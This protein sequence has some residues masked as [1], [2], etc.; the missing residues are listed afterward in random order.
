[1]AATAERPSDLLEKWAREQEILLVPSHEMMTE[2]VRAIHAVQE[3]IIEPA[4][5]AIKQVGSEARGL[6][7]RSLDKPERPYTFEDVG[8]LIAWTDELRFELLY[9]LDAIKE[10]AL[11]AH[12]DVAAL[13]QGFVPD[14]ETLE[15]SPWNRMLCRMHGFEE[16][17]SS[18]TRA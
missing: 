5:Q 17:N 6:D 15:P 10:V 8:R 16:A 9:A 3:F 12:E 4:A 18:G 1:M 11:L 14:G 2:A 13:A 7:A